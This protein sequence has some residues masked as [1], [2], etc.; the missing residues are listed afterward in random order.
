MYAWCPIE[1][2]DGKDVSKFKINNHK[3]KINMKYKQTMNKH[4][5]KTKNRNIFWTV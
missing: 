4:E 3:I 2:I 1:H 5:C